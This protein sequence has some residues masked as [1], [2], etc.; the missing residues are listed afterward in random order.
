[1]HVEFDATVIKTLISFDDPIETMQK[2]KAPIEWRGQALLVISSNVLPTFP[3]DDGGLSSRVSMVRFP[4]TFVQKPSADDDDDEDNAK[5]CDEESVGEFPPTP[6]ER[7]QDP[8]VKL[9]L[10]KD[11]VPEFWCWA[12][13]FNEM[14]IR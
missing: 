5:M 11:L 3:S 1:M 2:Y 10:M 4:F 9:M 6:G 13:F 12:T 7:W 14:L 8:D